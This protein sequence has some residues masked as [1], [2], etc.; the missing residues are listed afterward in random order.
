MVVQ[1]ESD[2]LKTN[3]NTSP[4]KKYLSRICTER[5][6]LLDRLACPCNKTS[7]SQQFIKSLVLVKGSLIFNTNSYFGMHG[8]K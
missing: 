8:L 1:E 7:Q 2:G 6:Y 5:A 3:P 4:Y